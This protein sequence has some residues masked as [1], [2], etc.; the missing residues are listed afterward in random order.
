MIVLKIKCRTY[1]SK[2]LL[3]LRIVTSVSCGL[4]PSPATAQSFFE[5]FS[6]DFLRLPENLL[7]NL[8]EG[9]FSSFKDMSGI[10]K[11]AR[12]R[13]EPSLVGK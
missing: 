2:F 13:Q 4:I 7:I 1:M 11:M 12:S 3:A 10:V 5:F 8:S 6:E 9:R